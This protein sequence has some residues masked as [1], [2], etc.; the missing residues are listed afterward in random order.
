MT[1]ELPPVLPV[2]GHTA[3]HWS[4][5]RKNGSTAAAFTGFPLNI[6][7]GK[8][9]VR[10]AT[11]TRTEEEMMTHHLIHQEAYWRDNPGQPSASTG[12][13]NDALTVDGN[14]ASTVDGNDASTGNENYASTG[15]ENIASDPSS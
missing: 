6:G 12:N 10:T 1:H 2:L 4:G 9:F 3:R 8:R 14:D 13:G 11:A 5:V 7:K 15:N